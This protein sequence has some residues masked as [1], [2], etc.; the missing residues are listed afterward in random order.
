[1]KGLGFLEETLDLIAPW[2]DTSTVSFGNRVKLVAAD[3][4]AGLVR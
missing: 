3:G 1:M 4:M 2:V